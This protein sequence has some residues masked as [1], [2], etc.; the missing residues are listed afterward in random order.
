M[1]LSLAWFTVV[2]L[3]VVLSAINLYVSSQLGELADDR[4]NS[5]ELCQRV[6]SS[7]YLEYGV[8]L[9][10]TLV[11]LGQGSWLLALAQLPAVVSHASRLHAGS[12]L[13]DPASIVPYNEQ[14]AARERTRLHTYL[15]VGTLCM[16][17]LG[18]LRS[19]VQ[20][21]VASEPHHFIQVFVPAWLL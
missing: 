17:V 4:L 8:H 15:Y 6:N 10:V 13:Y 11:L 5:W 18:L 9:A 20:G 19:V 7:V 16:S 14:R 2:A 3:S 12:A 21:M 1:I